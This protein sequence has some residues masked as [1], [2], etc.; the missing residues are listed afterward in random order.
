MIK[1]ENRLNRLRDLK[2]QKNLIKERKQNKPVK[3]FLKKENKKVS[4]I[5]VIGESLLRL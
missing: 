4:I 1:K 3:A 2:A 5:N